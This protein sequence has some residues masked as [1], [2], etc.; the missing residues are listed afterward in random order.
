MPRSK[1]QKVAPKAE[2]EKD[3]ARPWAS[4]PTELPKANEAVP[5]YGL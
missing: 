2:E 3:E 1:K 4:W 5:E